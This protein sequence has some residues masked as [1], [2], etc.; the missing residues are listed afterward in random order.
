MEP[1]SLVRSHTTAAAP[2]A[3]AVQV[4]PT[5]VKRA[6]RV[7]RERRGRRGRGRSGRSFGLPC[8]G[9]LPGAGVGRPVGRRRRGPDVEAARRASVT[10]RT[11]GALSHAATASLTRGAHHTAASVAAKQTT[12]T[13]ATVMRRL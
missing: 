1:S 3:G 5:S 2:A 11:G 13:A 6:A 7:E 4:R 10:A 12:A 8:G 9:G